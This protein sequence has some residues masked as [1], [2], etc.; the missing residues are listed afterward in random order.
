M[1]HH[2]RLRPPFERFEST[3]RIHLSVVFDESRRLQFDE[4][5]VRGQVDVVNASVLGCVVQ[6]EAVHLGPV[7]DRVRAQPRLEDAAELL[8]LVDSLVTAFIGT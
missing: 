2:E 3:K 7:E 1:T 6:L 8:I 4:D 5:A